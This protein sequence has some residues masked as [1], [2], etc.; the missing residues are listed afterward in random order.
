MTLMPSETLAADAP[1]T[2]APPRQITVALD[3]AGCPN[4]CRH[5]YLGQAAGGVMQPDD[6][7]WAVAQFRAYVHPRETRPYFDEIKV[8]SWVREP[9]LSADYRGLYALE[10]ELDD[11]EPDRFEL[12]SIYRLARDATYA[13]W[14]QEIGTEACQISFFGVGATQD[15]FYRRRGAFDDCLVATERLLAH[16]IAPR[17]QIFCTTKLLPELGELLALIDRLELHKRSAAIGRPFQV[18]VHTPAPD[19]EARHIEHLRPRLDEVANLPPSLMQASRT[20]L[21]REQMWQTEAQWLEELQT[22]G[23]KG[24]LTR[25]FAYGMPP[26]LVFYI[27]PDWSVYTNIGTLEPWWNLGNLRAEGVATI[28][29]RLERA[30][31]LGYDTIYR[32]DP[33]ALA[34]QQGERQGQRIYDSLNDLLGLY[35]GRHCFP[36]RSGE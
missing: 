10:Q 14:A 16:G 5:C 32:V 29:L 31:P 23:S 1:A 21:G 18:F 25:P 11:G 12:L 8:S 33:L 34:R 36:S 28:L 19:G 15:W 6:L 17:W 35:V 27:L 2:I 7:R 13:R 3:M 26:R 22:R 4:R 30:Q 20:Y 9:D 24:E